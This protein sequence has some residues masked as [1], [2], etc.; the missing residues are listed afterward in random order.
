MLLCDDTATCWWLQSH[1]MQA[2]HGTVK[3]SPR[4]GDCNGHTVDTSLTPSLLGLQ[5]QSIVDLRSY[6]Q[7]QLNQLRIN[8]QYHIDAPVWTYAL[9]KLSACY[10][11]VHLTIFNTSQSAITAQSADPQLQM[12]HVATF[13]PASTHIQSVASHATSVSQNLSPK[14]LNSTTPC[15]LLAEPVVPLSGLQCCPQ[16]NSTPMAAG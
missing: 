8:H 10:S 9:Y 5:Y 12:L 13:Q 7:I 11:D 15:T 3:S 4:R 1:Y 14:S 16:A 6:L 2:K